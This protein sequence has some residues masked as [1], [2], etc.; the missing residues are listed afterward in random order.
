ML[1]RGLQLSQSF[2]RSCVRLPIAR[3]ATTP[4]I[5]FSTSAT[6][7][8]KIPNH[9]PDAQFDR[10]VRNGN[11]NETVKRQTSDERSRRAP[12]TPRQARYPDQTVRSTTTNPDGRHE[13][14]A[15]QARPLIRTVAF[16][17]KKIRPLVRYRDVVHQERNADSRKEENELQAPSRKQESEEQLRSVARA[18]RYS[19]ESDNVLKDVPELKA[20]PAVRI[21]RHLA[22]DP[23]EKTDKE[24]RLQAHSP[25][26]NLRRLA[27][28]PNEKGGEYER[29][30]PPAARP[31]NWRKED[32]LGESTANSRLDSVPAKQPTWAT[33]PLEKPKRKRRSAEASGARKDTETGY[34][35][36][37]PS[38]SELQAW[39]KEFTSERSNFE[40]TAQS[41]PLELL[42][43]RVKKSLEHD[44][45]EN[46]KE[47]RRLEGTGFSGPTKMDSRHGTVGPITL[48]QPRDE[49]DTLVSSVDMEEKPAVEQ[50]DKDGGPAIIVLDCVSRSL[51]E[52]DFRHIAGHGQHVDGWTYGLVKS[53]FARL[54]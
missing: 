16:S 43:L 11:A 40:A 17:P 39:F 38:Q 36:V 50:S 45:V 13:E 32:F 21:I 12:I 41:V 26:R 19:H 5:A 7:C 37:F 31:V 6:R 27:K 2:N 47:T 1:P 52:S 20:R 49:F 51:L 15:T 42:Q 44:K 46:E 14:N 23:I 18:A 30:V 48:R 28:T 3:S 24:P 33:S 22:R 29:Q 54:V 53:T 8:K 9:N 25:A 4:S 10:G 34:E 35:E